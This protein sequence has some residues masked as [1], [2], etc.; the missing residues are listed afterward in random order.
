M[1]RSAARVTVLLASRSVGGHLASR[2]G[3][4]GDET[5]RPDWHGLAIDE[6][7]SVAIND[8]YTSSAPSPR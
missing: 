7:G 3:R 5:S 4:Y 1:S 2:V 6:D 8:G